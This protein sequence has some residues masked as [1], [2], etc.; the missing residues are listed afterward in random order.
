MVCIP[1]IYNKPYV[2]TGSDKDYI[3]V[4]NSYLIDY[5]DKVNN[6]LDA[7][8]ISAK[9]QLSENEKQTYLFTIDERIE[10][11]QSLLNQY[12][13]SRFEATE[14]FKTLMV[15]YKLELSKKT[16]TTKDTNFFRFR[17][18][19]QA[20]VERDAHLIDGKYVVFHIPFSKRRFVDN[21]RFNSHGAP[22]FYCSSNLLTAWYETKKPGSAGVKMSPYFNA[23]IYKNHEDLEFLDFSLKDINALQIKAHNSVNEFKEFISYLQLFPLIAALHTKVGYS[24]S[25]EYIKFKF[26]YVFPTLLMDWF[27]SKEKGALFSR[28]VPIAALRYSS[29]ENFVSFD[30]YNYAIPTTINNTEYCQTL[31]DQFL[32][33]DKYFYI[34]HDQLDPSISMIDIPQISLIESSLI[35]KLKRHTGSAVPVGP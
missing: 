13:I 21:G 17:P 2:I 4:L 26:E 24:E 20:V 5:R 35:T 19:G 14:M 12:V 23:A 11:I 22:C 9:I 18:D 15:D 8:K 29:A 30:S 7:F 33:K 16:K 1:E 28:P 32:Q 27:L 31:T 6:I 3:S 34:Y 25:S 10:N